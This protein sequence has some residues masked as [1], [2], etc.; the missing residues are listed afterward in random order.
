MVSPNLSERKGRWRFSDGARVN[1]YSITD[2]EFAREVKDGVRAFRAGDS[3]DC[4]VHQTQRM[5]SNGKLDSLVKTRFEEVPA[6]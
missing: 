5:E 2:Q 3:F 1:W 4:E 6:L